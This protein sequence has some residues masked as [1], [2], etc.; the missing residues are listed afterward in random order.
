M[1]VDLRASRPGVSPE[2]PAASLVCP[3]SQPALG[4]N[5]GASPRWLDSNRI[6]LLKLARVALGSGMRRCTIHLRILLRPRFLRRLSFVH[7][8]LSI[9]PS[10][11]TCEPPPAT[12]RAVP[13]SK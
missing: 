10:M 1:S 11:L 13:A 12:R 8:T 4:L 7:E 5:A 6:C 2:S 3:S 9:S